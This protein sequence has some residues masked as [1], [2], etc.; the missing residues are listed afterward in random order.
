MQKILTPLYIM[1]NN[2]TISH[3]AAAANAN[4][5]AP[6]LG[7]QQVLPG[8]ELVPPLCPPDANAVQNFQIY[9]KDNMTFD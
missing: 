3:D 1:D 5:A 7:I 4:G 6:A 9:N 2:N 8:P